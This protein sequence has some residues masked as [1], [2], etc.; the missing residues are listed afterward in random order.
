METLG[1]VTHELK[2]PLAAMQSMIDVV[3]KGYTGAVPE[4][5]ASYLHRIRHSGEELQDMVKNYLDLSRAER[6]EL[7]A[8]RVAVELRSAIVDPSVSA[9]QPLFDSRAIELEV[10]CPS[11]VQVQ[12]DPE[13]MRI[14]LTN[15]LTNAAKY[16][17]RNGSAQL[18]VHA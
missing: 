7:V 4:K 3:V 16:G 13:L 11:D 8:V 9:T 17:R 1:F 12:V 6:G 18:E 2:A 15:Y 5:M 14:A 10:V